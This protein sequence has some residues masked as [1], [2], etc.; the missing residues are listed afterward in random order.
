MLQIY[1]RAVVDG[2]IQWTMGNFQPAAGRFEEALRLA[3]KLKN[4]K[5]E[6]FCL[7]KLGLLNWN[8]GRMQECYQCYQ[9][10]LSMA[11]LA[12]LKREERICL[13][14][15]D[16][17]DLYTKGKEARSL[18]NYQQSIEFLQKAVEMARGIQSREHEVKCLRQMSVNYW[19]QNKFKEFYDMNIEAQK[20]AQAVHHRRE[21]GICYNNIGIFYWKMSNYSKALKYFQL[22]LEI[23]E[24]ENAA[25]SKSQCLTNISLIY[26]DLGYYEKAL[27]YLVQAL[28]FDRQMKND[29]YV[30]I[31]LNNV[32]IIY[33]NLAVVSERR[34][35]LI[36]SINS[37][38]ESINLAKKI[39]NKRNECT[40]LIN[41]G[42]A[43][44]SLGNLERALSNF[45]ASLNVAQ[46]IKNKELI[47]YNFNN[48]GNIYLASNNYQKAS[49]YFK[50]SIELALKI[51]NAKILW[52]AYYGLGQC[53]EKMGELVAAQDS[54]EKSIDIIEKIRS[55]IFLDT[56]KA[57][58]VRN[59]LKVYESMMLLL[60]EFMRKDKSKKYEKEIFHYIEKV[61]AR[62]FL[63][64]LA[65]SKIDIRENLNKEYREEENRISS[66]IASILFN[67]SRIGLSE[68]EK[69]GLEQ[70]L[71]QE[72][73]RY[74]RLISKMRDENPETASLVAPEPSRLDQVQG[75]LRNNKTALI[76][77]FLGEKQSYMILIT[78][79]DIDLYFLP[80]RKD[81]EKSVK[82]YI[83][84][85]SGPLQ[86]ALSGNLGAVRLFDE[87]LFPIKNQKYRGVE[88]LVIVP[89]GIL[90]YLPFETLI[91]EQKNQTLKHLIDQYQ[92]SYTP[93]SSVLI[94]LLG[95]KMEQRS[96]IG[97]LAFG[98][99]AYPNMKSIS[100]KKANY[101][102]VMA[103]FYLDQGFKYFPIPYTRDEIRTISE[104]FQKSKRDV[105]LGQNAR[106]ENVKKLHHNYYQIV[107][108]ACHGFLDEKQPFRSALVLSQ[109]EEKEEDGF[110]QVRELYNIRLEAN[111]VVLSAC[112]TGRG[113]LENGEGILG[114]TR[115][116]FYSG[117]RSVLSTLWSVHDKS[118]A[119]FM[120][121]FYSHLAKGHKIGEALR[122]TKLEMMHSR[123]SHPY[124]WAGFV[125]NGDYDLR[126]DFH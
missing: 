84:L 9:E 55:Q 126:I 7:T 110:L 91:S 116:F 124:Y 32:G 16:I 26:L 62:A 4:R 67:I 94:S 28:K 3:K 74:M 23:A 88:K 10:G 81:I 2:E 13:T 8:L 59:K 78:K 121:I 89:D 18:G 37:F 14:A 83:K 112:H 6:V 111:L 120:K 60:S 76:E 11:R 24:K 118:T 54:Y 56:F 125:L 30:S 21:E 46:K 45:N 114:L 51:N 68:S 31:D 90:Y 92:V 100:T 17:Y 52:E 104:Y 87:L 48:I 25:E 39:D 82:G 1:K 103:N 96:P 58:F 113:K 20:I 64:G 5:E 123:F 29:N 122:L 36:A 27:E 77:Y 33:R 12:K 97:L 42:E 95:K 49:D 86:K 22:S 40:A 106:E 85:I 99:P 75:I 98:D 101:E 115:M 80:S 35:D 41:I 38:L 102:N 57:G 72:E 44:F 79:N 43:Y 63:E 105:Y 71:S 47:S 15:L 19:E 107:H 108:F 69:K 66:Q 93:S 73:D 109:N 50:H 34:E 70:R 61:K 117:A 119:V 65:E 53:Y